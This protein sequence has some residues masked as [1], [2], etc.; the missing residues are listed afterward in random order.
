[1]TLVSVP[2]E[3][4]APERV[5]LRR[6]VCS[7]SPSR[8]GASAV[9]SVVSLVAKL[10]APGRL[11]QQTSTVIGSVTTRSLLDLTYQ[12]LGIGFALVPALLPCT[13][14]AARRRAYPGCSGPGPRASASPA[15][16]LDSG[17]T[18]P[19]AWRWPP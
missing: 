4:V 15:G 12:L 16:P 7:S 3:T 19:G 9:Y 10:T 14:S 18:S 17:T 2:V 8:S 13:S 6:E 5:R 11:S 1:M